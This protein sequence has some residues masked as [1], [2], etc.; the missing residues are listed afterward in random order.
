MS[1]PYD[2]TGPGDNTPSRRRIFTCRP[3]DGDAGA[4]C[5]R[6]IISTVAR[7]AYRRPVTDVDVDVL[8]PFYTAGHDRGGFEVGIETALRR[9]PKA[10]VGRAG[11]FLY[12]RLIPR[13]RRA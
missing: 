12:G 10:R 13:Q 4:A 5:A 7:R 8:L 9:I 3:D 6:T 2:P 1:G 11:F